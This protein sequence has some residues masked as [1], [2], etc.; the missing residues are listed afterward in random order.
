M[1]GLINRMN[2]T[3]IAFAAPPVAWWLS[4][5]LT[6]LGGAFTAACVLA[7]ALT[8]STINDKNSQGSGSSSDASSSLSASTK[9]QLNSLRSLIA[10][11]L[12]D[13]T[14]VDTVKGKAVMAA[15]LATLII[16]PVI[17]V[18]LSSLA[19]GIILEQEYNIMDKLGGKLHALYVYCD[20]LGGDEK[21]VTS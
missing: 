19:L 8:W 12:K 2:T 1:S 3:T 21:P 6:L 11:F 4:H 9:E 17:G 13:V 5:G 14:S 10:G 15:G 16:S 20:K 18:I 7:G